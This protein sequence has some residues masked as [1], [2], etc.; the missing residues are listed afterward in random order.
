MELKDFVAPVPL[1][2][3]VPNPDA[4][5]STG[6]I[7]GVTQ[8]GQWHALIASYDT[9]PKG[10]AEARADVAHFAQALSGQG[11][12]GRDLY[13]VRTTISNNYAVSVDAGDDRALANQISA[14]IRRLHHPDGT[15]RDSFVQG[16]R[17]WVIDP[18]CASFATLSG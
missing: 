7:V 13:I 17:G 3:P 2:G 8:I 15:G 10:C 18:E 16:N 1:P 11:L 9:T 6:A 5:N 14:T 12:E 4:D